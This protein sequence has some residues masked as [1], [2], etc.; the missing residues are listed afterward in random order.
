MTETQ[1][2][3]PTGETIAS[4][5]SQTGLTIQDLSLALQIINLSAS[6]GAFRGNELTEVGALHDRIY[7]FLDSI[8]AITRNPA[9]SE[10]PATPAEPQ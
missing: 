1:E 4:P 6:R 7:R 2:K 5:G 9:T 3:A 10:T 8:G